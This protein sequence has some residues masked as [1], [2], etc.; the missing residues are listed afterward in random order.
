MFHSNAVSGKRQ[1]YK[2]ASYTLHK[3]IKT[4][5]HAYRDRMEAQFNTGKCMEPVAWSADSEWF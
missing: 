4:A 2:K 1:K 3:T 5:K